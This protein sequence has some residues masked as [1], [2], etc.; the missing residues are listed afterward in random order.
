[1]TMGFEWDQVQDSLTRRRYDN[2]MATYVILST[3]KSKVKGHTITVKYSS[4][5]DPNNCGPSPTQ[6]A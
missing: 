4:S 1:M 3:K 2:V 6:E 5:P